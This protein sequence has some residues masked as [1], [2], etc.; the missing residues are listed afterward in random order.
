MHPAA[1]QALKIAATLAADSAIRSFAKGPEPLA[2]PRPA[3]LSPSG[4]SSDLTLPSG[5][6]I[7]ITELGKK[8]GE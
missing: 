7:R 8:G 3:H 2:P 4:P 1:V 6:I 5:T